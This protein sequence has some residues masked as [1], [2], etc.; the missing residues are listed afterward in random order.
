MTPA[1]V[2]LLLLAQQTPAETATIPAYQSSPARSPMLPPE[3]LPQERAALPHI[4][5]AMATAGKELI[6]NFD[7]A[8]GQ[9]PQP[10]PFRGMVLC[11]QSEALAAEQEEA[12][13]AAAID[14]CYRLLPDN[15]GAQML[16]AMLYI[17]HRDF[18]RAAPL[19]AAAIRAAPEVGNMFPLERVGIVLTGLDY[20]RRDDIR[21]QFVR[22]LV[23]GGFGK[24]DPAFYSGLA[25]QAV[26]DHVRKRDIAG[27]VALLPGITDPEDGLMMLIDRRFDPI[28]P[29]LEEWA[30]NDLVV[31][32]DALVSQS[33][34]RANVEDTPE[35]RLALTAIL[36]RTGHRDE[37]KR[38]LSETVADPASWDDYRF[39][40][41]MSAVRLSRLMREDGAIGDAAIQ[42]MLTV[43][44]NMPITL[45]TGG[46]HTVPP[47]LA[48]SYL[49]QGRHDQ[50]LAVADR[51]TPKVDEIYQNEDIG[52][53][54]AA[55]VCALHGK[56]DATA[57][58]LRGDLMTRYAA[59]IKA[60]QMAAQCVGDVQAQ[61]LRLRRSIEEERDR[62]A[63]LLSVARARRRLAQGL[64]AVEDSRRDCGRR[65]VH[66]SRPDH[67]C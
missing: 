39:A 33:R 49:L 28:W 36:E 3:P 7:L 17:E 47:N 65:T 8:L 43:M 45:E 9:L 66:R 2:I 59:N 30:H 24:D 40:A 64:P 25:R 55:R 35:A 32:R 1:V 57:E 20:A 31:Q 48:R 38:L 19:I 18:V 23:D 46:L 41:G 50:A 34:A 62:S 63:G 61:A 44:G 58:R 53:M 12:R 6:E 4:G 56:G 37:A 26:L 16:R 15:P 10:T 52:F 22:A 51:Y 60:N 21:E 67:A 42:P 14:E 29:Q 13:A 27:A 11:M 54:V 5:R